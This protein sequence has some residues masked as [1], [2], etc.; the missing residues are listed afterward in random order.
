MK[1]EIVNKHLIMPKNCYYDRYDYLQDCNIILSV[2][3]G[4][5]KRDLN[6]KNK[7]LTYLPVF[8]ITIYIVEKNPLRF[9]KQKVLCPLNI[10][11]ECIWCNLRFYD[12][13]INF[14]HE[15]C[16]IR[17]FLQFFSSYNLPLLF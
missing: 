6:K 16:R 2:Q 12:E 17:K 8:I 7:N 11:D 5:E 1:H 15:S 4:L 13:K 9:N 3:I 10:Y 14:D